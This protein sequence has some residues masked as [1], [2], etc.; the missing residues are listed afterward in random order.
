M[1]A[2]IYTLLACATACSSEVG[3][4][5]DAGPPGN[6]DS[7]LSSSD[8]A[9]DPERN[10][11]TV[12]AHS[13]SQLYSIDPDSLAVT[14]VGDFGWPVG[15][16]DSMTDVAVDRDGNMIGVSFTKVYSVD[17]TTAQTTFLADLQGEF[18]GLSFVPTDPNDPDSQ[19]ELVAAA[20]T[21]MVYRL[22]PMTGES[23][24]VGAYGGT[25][26]S[27]G[28]IV[29]VTGFGTVATVKDGVNPTDLLVRIDPQAGYEATLIGDTMVTDIWGLGFW[30]DRVYGFSDS[31]GFV[32]IDTLTGKAQSVGQSDIHWWGAGVTTSA[33]VIID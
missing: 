20:S 15:T 22:D 2:A 14:L 24:Q 8:A 28:D 5:P 7:G 18:N 27:S 19:E 10:D 32:L 23:T 26:R 25:F 16:A 21:G 11:A 17:T 9:R 29:S 30:N 33:P 1:K 31:D 3:G 6:I 4:A 13:S 12:F